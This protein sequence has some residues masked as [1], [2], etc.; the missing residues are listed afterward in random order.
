[1]PGELSPGSGGQRLGH[2]S[3]APLGL[4]VEGIHYSGLRPALRGLPGAILSRPFQGRLFTFRHCLNCRGPFAACGSL[5]LTLSRDLGKCGPIQWGV[6][7][8]PDTLIQAPTPEIVSFDRGTV[9]V[10]QARQ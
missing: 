4:K 6:E 2:S 9:L 3:A 10:A 5:I 8:P 1:M 7:E